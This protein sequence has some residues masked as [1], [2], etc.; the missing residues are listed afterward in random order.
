MTKLSSIVTG[1][2]ISTLKAFSTL[3]PPKTDDL[4]G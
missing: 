1:Y 3:R 2:K 4:D